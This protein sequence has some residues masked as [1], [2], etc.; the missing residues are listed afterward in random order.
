MENII[1]SL[2]TSQV[3]YKG[4][5]PK[6]FEFEEI[7]FF[8]C[9]NVLHSY[10][11]CLIATLDLGIGQMDVKTTFLHD[12]LEKE[13][14]IE[15]PKSFVVKGKEYYVCKLKKTLYVLKQVPRQWYKKFRTILMGKIDHCVFVQEFASDDFIILSL[16]GDDILIVS[17][18]AS[19][20]DEL[21]KQLKQVFLV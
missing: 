14:Y 4:V 20:I 6:G 19:N 3:G 10:S 11:A 21:Q 17:K 7:F 18:K 5:Q 15:Q 8:C 12:D 16:Y 13:I 9:E 1:P 2:V